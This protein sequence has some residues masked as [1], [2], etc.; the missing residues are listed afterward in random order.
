M[1]NWFWALS[2]DAV[3]ARCNNEVL[4]R[5]DTALLRHPF[6]SLIRVLADIPGR[7]G[8]PPVANASNMRLSRT[9]DRI[10]VQT[11]ASGKSHRTTRPFDSARPGRITAL[12]NNAILLARF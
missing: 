3:C 5:L 4:S 8:Q 11:T 10:N 1:G 6:I 12:A 7:V 9:E 2:Q